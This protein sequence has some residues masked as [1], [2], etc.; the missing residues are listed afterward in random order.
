METI[1]HETSRELAYRAYDGVE[2]TLLWR[3][4]DDRLTVQVR[5]AKCGDF[6]ELDAESDKALEVFH[7]PYAHAAFQGL[8]YLAGRREVGEAAFA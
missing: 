3:S 6:L 2:V 1:T 5:D 8:P 4:F 7:H